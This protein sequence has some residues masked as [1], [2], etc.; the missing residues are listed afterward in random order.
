MRPV[1]QASTASDLQAD[2]SASTVA[3]KPQV[4][5]PL[6]PA[7][8]EAPRVANGLNFSTDPIL[9]PQAVQAAAPPP[10]DSGM[11]EFDLGALSLD[12]DSP[13]AGSVAGSDDPLATKF[14]LAEEFRALG[15]MEGARSLAEEVAAQSQ[16]SL[17]SKA[18]AFIGALS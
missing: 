18:Q 17:K 6:L 7:A 11:L 10:L 4:E 2:F 8:D 14:A 13:E 12:L 15:D 1:E 9:A 5:A 3:L 16:G